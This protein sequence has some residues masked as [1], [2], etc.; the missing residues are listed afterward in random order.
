MAALGV[1]LGGCSDDLPTA[2]DE[3]FFPPG[4]TPLTLQRIYQPEEVYDA[5]GSFSGYTDRSDASF[6]ITAD[7][8][9]AA[10]EANILLRFTGFP[11]R[12]GYSSE[13][14]SITDSVFSYTGGRV[15]AVVDSARSASE[16]QVTLGLWTLEQAWDPE[17]VSW[18]LAVDTAGEQSPWRE[19]G[20]TRGRL[21]SELTWAPGDTIVGDSLT[22]TVDSVAVRE[23]A[24]SAFPG[25]MVTA[26]GDGSRLEI[27][28]FAVELDISPETVPD[29]T[30]VETVSSG[31]REFVFTPAQPS[32]GEL[33]EVGGLESARHLFRLHFPEFLPAG[34]CPPCETVPISEVSLNQVALVLDPEPASGGFRPLAPI[35]VT[36]R[37]IAEPE[38]GMSAPLGGR[39]ASETLARESFTSPDSTAVLDLTNFVR[40]IIA[41]REEDEED[42]DEE[43]ESELSR[44]LALLAEPLA[45]TFGVAW[46]Q[47]RPLLRF[48]YTIPGDLNLP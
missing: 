40:S 30:L 29:T 3:R 4:S 42:G 11:E 16:G 18:E 8:F 24:D 14:V 9:D 10:L 5:L 19:P 38:L 34:P 1:A 46:F 36:I 28:S 6:L 15:I 32:P 20:G 27:G 33:L 48:V 12:V 45:G 31:P 26:K 23:M 47:P 13:G 39:L 17:S 7:R 35:T 41:E 44:E 21:L 43:E 37:A 25:L 22:W 2:G